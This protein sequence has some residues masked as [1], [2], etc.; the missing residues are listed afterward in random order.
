MKGVQ[1]SFMKNTI[2]NEYPIDDVGGI[3]TEPIG[4]YTKYNLRSLLQYCR[5]NNIQPEDLNEEKLREFELT[6]K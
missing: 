6:D 5:E 2:K 3:L 1:K 4:E